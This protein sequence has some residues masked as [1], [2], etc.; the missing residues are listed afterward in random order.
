[1]EKRRR[2]QEKKLDVFM[3]ITCQRQGFWLGLGA[4]KSTQSAT[5]NVAELQ[6][7][8]FFRIFSNSKRKLF[9]KTFCTLPIAEN[10]NHGDSQS[11]QSQ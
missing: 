2:S 7:N 9:R 5:L 3:T 1:M 6:Q 8:N 10:F 4:K 11:C